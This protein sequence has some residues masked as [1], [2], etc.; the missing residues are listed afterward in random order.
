MRL[1]FR[2]HKI[3]G[4]LFFFIE[5]YLIYSVVLVSVVQQSDSAIHIYVFFFVIDYYKI[6]NVV[7]VLYSRTLLFICFI[8]SSVY[9]LGLPRWCKC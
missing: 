2:G 6:V 5:E 4:L 9:L 8:Y 7:P 1:N 3:T